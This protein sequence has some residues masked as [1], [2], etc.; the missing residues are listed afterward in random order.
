VVYRRIFCD[1]GD[2]RMGSDTIGG[3]MMFLVINIGCI[4]CGVSSQVVG[5]FKTKEEADKI[6]DK[7]IEKYYWRHGGQNEFTVFPLPEV[8]V[9]N[10]EYEL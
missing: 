5:L 9:I 10:S 1:S 3:E 4:E 7:C 6:A 2:Y 8:G